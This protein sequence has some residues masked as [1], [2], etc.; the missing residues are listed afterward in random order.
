MEGYECQDLY[1]HFVSLEKFAADQLFMALWHKCKNQRNIFAD[2]NTILLNFSSSFL[3]ASPIVALPC[4][5][6]RQRPRDINFLSSFI[7]YF[8]FDKQKR[9]KFSSCFLWYLFSTILVLET[10]EVKVVFH[11]GFNTYAGKTNIEYD[12][13]LP[14]L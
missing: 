14:F 12:L 3:L 5:S 6:L 1:Y 11:F 13:L 2:D 8:F 7:W 4:Q 9:H 10:E